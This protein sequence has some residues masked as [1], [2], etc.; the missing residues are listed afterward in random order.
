MQPS[1][2]SSATDPSQSSAAFAI[3][4]HGSISSATASRSSALAVTGSAPGP[5]PAI[6]SPRGGPLDFPDP[7][8]D[9]LPDL[10]PDPLPVRW[11]ASAAMRSHVRSTY[12]QA[13]QTGSPF[14][15][16]SRAYSC[17]PPVAGHDV[18]AS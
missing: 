4:G 15:S 6:G 12:P 7:L 10:L 9:P 8:P 1:R 17:A 18:E 11:G 16:R 14:A 13:A 2:A 5:G 3:R